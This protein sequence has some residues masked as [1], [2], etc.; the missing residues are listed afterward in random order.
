MDEE[1]SEL[2]HYIEIGAIEVVGVDETGEFILG[3]TERAKDL[4][5]D[6]WAAHVEHVDET[7]LGLY[8]AGMLNVDYNEDLEAIFT[9]SEE[10]LQVAKEHGLMPLEINEEEIPNN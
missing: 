7:L 2:D 3:I 6:L 4:A 9:L 10:G 8:E 5:P 1:M